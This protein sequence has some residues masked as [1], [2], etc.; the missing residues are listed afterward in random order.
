MRAT[1]TSTISGTWNKVNSSDIKTAYVTT[2]G[3]TFFGTISAAGA[4]YLHGNSTDDHVTF[5]AEL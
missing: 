5:D 3:F 1:P 2:K 4:W